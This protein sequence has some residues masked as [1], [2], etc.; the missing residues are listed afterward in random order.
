MDGGKDGRQKPLGNG[1]QNISGK[2]M[3]DMTKTPKPQEIADKNIRKVGGKLITH[4]KDKGKWDMKD[5]VE[6]EKEKG[7]EK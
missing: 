3:A 1:G 6:K 4:G 7:K 5:A 2:R